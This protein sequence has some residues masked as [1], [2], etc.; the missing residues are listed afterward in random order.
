MENVSQPLIIDIEASGLGSHSYP[1]E[2][3]VALAD[4]S[5]FCRLI[6]PVS[7]WTHWDPQAESVHKISRSN[8]L[9]NGLSVT[10][11]ADALNEAFKGHRLFSDGWVVDQPW[12]TKLFYAAR[13]AMQ[14]QVSPLEA[15]L[16][17]PQMAIWHQTK[18]A[19]V[20]ETEITRHR[21]SNDAWLVQ[22]TYR[23]TLLK[24]QKS[25]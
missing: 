25:A 3:G 18:D 20:S 23:Q 17:E 4:G 9:A 22:E 15:I 16:S 11:V 13:R 21:A 19:I 1:I 24:T 2:V 5:K 12:L 7:D 8:L 14:F 10:E 6:T